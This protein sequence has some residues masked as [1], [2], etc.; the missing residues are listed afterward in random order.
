MPL[1]ILAVKATGGVLDGGGLT[2]VGSALTYLVAFDAIY[3]TVG[4]LLFEYVVRE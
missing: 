1:V 4:W 3:C 2:E